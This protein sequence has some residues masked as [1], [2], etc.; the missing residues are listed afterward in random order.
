MRKIFNRDVI[1][2]LILNIIFLLLYFNPEYYLKWPVD[3]N[4]IYLFLWAYPLYIL[5]FVNKINNKSNKA[6][7]FIL[8]FFLILSNIKG[9]LYYTPI[10][11]GLFYYKDTKPYY[12][13]CLDD[14]CINTYWAYSWNFFADN[15]LLITKDTKI[16]FLEKEINWSWMR[17]ETTEEKVKLTKENWK[18]L[19]TIYSTKKDIIK[20]IEVK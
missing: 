17:L 2:I 8:S 9:I 6:I 14:I 4:I 12:R 5:L 20:V 3:K 15:Y 11:Y 19:L 16:F 13:E 18:I 1:I 10:G 7:I